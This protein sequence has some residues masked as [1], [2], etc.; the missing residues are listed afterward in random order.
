MG[1]SKL[2]LNSESLNEKDKEEKNA[3]CAIAD[4]SLRDKLKKLGCQVVRDPSVSWFPSCG[5][6]TGQKL[7]RTME[8]KGVW[9]DQKVSWW[10]RRTKATQRMTATSPLHRS[11]E[12]SQVDRRW[13]WW[14][15][16]GR[17]RTGEQ[18]RRMKS[19]PWWH[20]LTAS[21]NQ[22]SGKQKATFGKERDI[23]QK[24]KNSPIAQACGR[25]E[26]IVCLLQGSRG[27]SSA[28]AILNVPAVWHWAT[29]LPSGL[30][31]PHLQNRVITGTTS[32]RSWI[33]EWVHV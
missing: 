29:F 15:R 31:F 11:L 19:A 17:K 25:E 7:E 18:R 6:G 13:P 28:D 1:R 12:E 30:L 33:I 4:L 14:Q 20:F 2:I 26:I 24:E 21:G 32:Q 16:I 5:F 27:F 9:W 10:P 22:G 8:K 3:F 23:I